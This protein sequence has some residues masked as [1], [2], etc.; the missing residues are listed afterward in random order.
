MQSDETKE[1]MFEQF[2]LND[3]LTQIK[4]C[5]EKEVP[6]EIKGFGFNNCPYAKLIEEEEREKRK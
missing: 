5:K 4:N 1:R 3:F 2:K 6:I